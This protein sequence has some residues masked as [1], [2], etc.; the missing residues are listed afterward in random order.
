MANKY[1]AIAEASRTEAESAL[2]DGDVGKLSRLVIGI[3]LY[4]MDREWAEAYCLDLCSH[5]DPNV[6]GN[7]I[8]ALGHL[9]RRFGCLNEPDA[10]PLIERGLKDSD[11]HVRGQAHAANDDVAHFLGWQLNSNS[12]S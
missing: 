8:L 3:G 7:A 1:E 11:E 5:V 6:R 10:R 2:K 9:A 4:E 12:P